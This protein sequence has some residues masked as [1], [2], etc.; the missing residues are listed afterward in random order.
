MITYLPMVWKI[1][2]AQIREEIYYSQINHGPFPEEQKGYQ[3]GNRETGNLFYTNIS[4]R[5]AK[6]GENVAMA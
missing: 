1:L 3:K 4:S 5:R 2:S 6:Q